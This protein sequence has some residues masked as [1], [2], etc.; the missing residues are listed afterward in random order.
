MNRLSIINRLYLEGTDIS[1][2]FFSTSCKLYLYLYE[3]ILKITDFYQ[4]FNPN[5]I[6]NFQNIKDVYVIT[7]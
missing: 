3:V 5:F 1:N 6:I 4:T 7:L 2:I